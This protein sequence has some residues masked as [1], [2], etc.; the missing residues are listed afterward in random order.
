MNIK[1]FKF[2]IFLLAN[3]TK[4]PKTLKEITTYTSNTPNTPNIHLTNIAICIG[5][6]GFCIK[7]DIQEAYEYLERKLIK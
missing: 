6:E 1:E 4:S 7:K 2:T 5:H 3:Y